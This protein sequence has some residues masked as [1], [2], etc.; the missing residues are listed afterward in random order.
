MS[1]ADSGGEAGSTGGHHPENR[2]SRRLRPEY[3]DQGIVLRTYKLGEADKILRV[4]TREHGKRSAVAKGVRKTSSRFGARLEPLSHV[5]LFLH[6]GRN[7]DTVKQAEIVNS[8][9][10]LRDDLDLFVMGSSMAELADTVAVADDPDPVLFDLLLLGLQLLK[11]YPARA[12][13]NLALFEFKLMSAAG[14][15]LMVGRCANCGGEPGEDVS[16]S[17]RLGGFVCGNCRTDRFGG[18]GKLVRV[19]TRC[20][21]LLSW[22]AAHKLGEWP[23]DVQPEVSAEVGALMGKVLEHWMER[24]FR[25]ARVRKAMPRR[26]ER[27]AGG[28][29]D[30]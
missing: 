2:G 28:R 7:M 21:D 27:T 13:L 12:E 17:L 11:E 8:F 14:F 15:E 29:S 10:E 23:G 20:A 6:R 19:S 4:L 5:K 25:S 24:E 3:Q 22:M 1:K 9:Q 18:A 16:F 26:T 30:G